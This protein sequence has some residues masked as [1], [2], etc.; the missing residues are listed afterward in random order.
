MNCHRLT[1]QIWIWALDRNI[2]ISAEHLPGS[3]N[4]LADAASR[5]IDVNKEWSLNNNV[6]T[7]VVE[8][9]GPFSIDLFA[10]RLNAKE[11]LFVSWKPDPSALFIDAFSRNWTQFNQF[12]AFPPFSLVLKCLHKIK[13]EESRGVLVIPVWPT[14]PWFPIAMN[15]LVAKPLLLP[16]N[17]LHLPYHPNL[18][19]PLSNNL[20]LL[21]CPLSGVFSEAETFQRSLSRSYASP[22]DH[23]QLGNMRFILKSGI[24]SVR[25]GTK[26]PFNMMKSW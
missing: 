25:S 12:Y 15:L 10:S 1:Q 5:K 16:K 7:K 24:I 8:Q 4:V 18:A 6:Y 3:E 26:I 9:F 22:G 23:Q 20:Y 17:V 21:A 2:H 11:T 13:K 14:Q 19:H